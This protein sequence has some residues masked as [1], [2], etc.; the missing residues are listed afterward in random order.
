M[1]ECPDEMEGV[2]HIFF[3]HVHYTMDGVEHEGILHHNGGAS[4]RF[5]NL[6]NMMEFEV[7][8]SGETENIKSIATQKGRDGR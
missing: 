2:K 1:K 6:F 7:S 4:I 5:R 3:G 8:P